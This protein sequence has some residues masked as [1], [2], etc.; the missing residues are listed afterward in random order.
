MKKK[1]KVILSIIVIF[2][3]LIIAFFTVKLLFS[4]KNNTA[5]IKVLDSIPNYNYTLDERDSKLMKDTYQELKGILKE[6]EINY[7]DYAKA[8]AKLFVID[9][10]TMN[11]KINKYDIGSI[12]YV[13]PDSISNFKI[14]V[15]DT[16]Y[17]TLENNADG[18][19]NQK[20]PA[21]KSILSSDIT[22][23]KYKLN[24]KEHDAYNVSLSWDYDEDLGYDDSAII[25]LIK[26]NKQLY[27]VQYKKG[28]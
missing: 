16:L 28:E 10:F 12:E 4:K 9:L 27:I 24:D 18:K 7:E 20:L 17:K 5:N 11:N 25:T 6:K 13:Y 3:L 19:R 26:E 1:Y 15:G 2:I 23:G 8:I 22:K 14:N 21:V